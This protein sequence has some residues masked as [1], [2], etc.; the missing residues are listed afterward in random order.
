MITIDI[1][2]ILQYQIPAIVYLLNISNLFLKKM[3]KIEKRQ[4]K[5]HSTQL[6]RFFQLFFHYLHILQNQIDCT[7]GKILSISQV[8]VVSQ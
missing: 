1:R 4:E 5:L 3:N 2:D 6:V 8:H 7:L